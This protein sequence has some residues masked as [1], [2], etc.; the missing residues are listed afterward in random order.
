[1]TQ[2][3]IPIQDTVQELHTDQSKKVT[4]C[5]ETGSNCSPANENAVEKNNNGKCGLFDFMANTVGLKVLHPGGYKATDE[6]CS[7]LEIKKD[8]H[9]LDV[10]CGYVLISIR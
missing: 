3:Q 2:S 8:S 7:T 10:A 4:S 9:V 5:N 6:L 1:M